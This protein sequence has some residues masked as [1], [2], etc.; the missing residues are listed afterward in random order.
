MDRF[1]WQWRQY[2]YV[3]IILEI[4]SSCE[5]MVLRSSSYNWTRILDLRLWKRGKEG[6]IACGVKPREAPGSL[7][8]KGL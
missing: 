5:K 6:I 8:D 2:D 1:D 7:A 4:Q 3:M